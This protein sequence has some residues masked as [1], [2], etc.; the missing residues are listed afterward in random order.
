MFD[1]QETLEKAV[2]QGNLLTHQTKKLH[3]NGRVLALTP[4]L[5]AEDALMFSSI[6]SRGVTLR[7]KM[8]GSTV[9]VDFQ[10]NDYLILWTCVGAPYLCI[11]PCS[12][13]P[14]YIDSDKDITRKPGMRRLASGE[15]GEHSHVVT[16][17]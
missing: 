14:D 10:G 7:S 1:E 13:L 16:F 6:H 12:N 3:T 2:L 4:E 11:E 5:F 9:R 17:G 15:S 8:D